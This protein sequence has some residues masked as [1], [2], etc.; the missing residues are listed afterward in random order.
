MR[1]RFPSHTK[2]CPKVYCNKYF[3]SR[4]ATMQHYCKEHAKTDLLCEECDTL[5]SMTGQ[6]N[7]INHYQ[8]K[9]PDSPIP[10]PNAASAASSLKSRKSTSRPTD[11]PGYNDRFIELNQKVAHHNGGPSISKPNGPITDMHREQMKRINSRQT[12]VST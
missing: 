1:W 11:I 4:Q 5:I 7:M 8:R 9:H 12:K 3:E 6:H 2:N 10:M